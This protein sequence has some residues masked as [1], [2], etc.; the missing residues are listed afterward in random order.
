MLAR[1]PETD[2]PTGTSPTSRSIQFRRTEPL[3]TTATE[4]PN[5]PIERG[6]PDQDLVRFDQGAN[7]LASQNGMRL[8]ISL[9]ICRR[10]A[11]DDDEQH[12]DRD[13]R[14]FHGHTPQLTA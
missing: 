13:T 3:T 8:R 1:M 7:E 2:A 5:L 11:C 14:L 10:L 12:R 6:I 9:R 4:S